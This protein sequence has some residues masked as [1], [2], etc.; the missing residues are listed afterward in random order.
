[1]LPLCFYAEAIEAQLGVAPE[2]LHVWLGSGRLESI[3]FSDVRAYW[4][5][6]RKQLAVAL[7]SVDESTSTTPVK[8]NHCTYCNFA[9]VCDAQWRNADA[10]QYV[11]GSRAVERVQPNVVH[12]VLALVRWNHS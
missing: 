9:D 7:D 12:A 8:C 11:A 3:R 5:R 4:R 6:L 1:M 10:V 2:Y